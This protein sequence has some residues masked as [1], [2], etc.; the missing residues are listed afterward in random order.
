MRAGALGA[1]V[2]EGM[3]LRQLVV[4]E[5][6]GMRLLGPGD[7]VLTGGGPP[8]MLV[9]E[10]HLRAIP[11]TRLAL[12]GSEFLLAARRWPSLFTAS[13]FAGLNRLTG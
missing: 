3:V 9:G 2:L 8:P 7:L 1:L 11:G 12:L 13:S 4:G 6:L 5:Q 10:S